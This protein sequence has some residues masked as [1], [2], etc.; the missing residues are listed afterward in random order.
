M[1][2]V[3]MYKCAVYRFPSFLVNGL[4]FAFLLIP[5]SPMMNFLVRLYSPLV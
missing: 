2:N 3:S 4:D 5:D 1:N